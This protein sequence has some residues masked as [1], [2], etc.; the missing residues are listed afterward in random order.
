MSHTFKISIIAGLMGLTAIAHGA[1]LKTKISSGI[2][3]ASGQDNTSGSSNS[4]LTAIPFTISW[5]SDKFS[6]S[7]STS[8]I[9]SKFGSTSASGMGDTSLTLGFDI[10]SQPWITLKGKYKFATGDADK[11]LSTGKD[12]LSLQLDFFQPTSTK[13][14]LFATVGYKFTGKVSGQSM[15]DTAY[16]SLGG[17]YL[18]MKGL[19]IGASMDYRQTTYTTLK[20]QVGFSLFLDKKLTKDLHTAVFGGYDNTDT[21]SFGLTFSYRL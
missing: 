19:S 11:G 18:P 4:T 10:T 15:Q 14:S 21:A 6:S 5:R 16:A 17:G 3:Y 20:D 9:D 2:F 1:P 8:Y 12:D 13:A 7:L